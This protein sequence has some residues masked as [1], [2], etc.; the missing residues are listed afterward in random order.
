MN[1]PI[2][3]PIPS[4]VLPASRRSFLK[5]GA[6]TA[7]GFALGFHL[8]AMAQKTGP[9]PSDAVDI[10]AWIRIT[11]DNQVVCEVARAEMG[12]GTSTSLPMMLAE[13][14]ECPWADV[15]MEFASV[16]EHLARNKV[17]VTFA[18]GGSR[19]TRDSQAVMRKAGAVAREMLKAAAAQQWG[20]PKSEAKRS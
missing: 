16:S 10:N 1:T 15:R 7:T 9:A 4:D 3:P 13:E 17:Y 8:P 14:L 18:T 2:L 20:V 19:G 12:Q 11:P 5:A 6:A